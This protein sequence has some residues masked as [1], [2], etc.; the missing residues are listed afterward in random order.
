MNLFLLNFTISWCNYCCPLSISFNFNLL[1]YNNLRFLLYLRF[2]VNNLL[3]F[4]WLRRLWYSNIFLR[5][6]NLLL[7]KAALIFSYCSLPMDWLTFILIVIG[8]LN[9]VWMSNVLER[10]SDLLLALIDFLL[11][12]SHLRQAFVKVWILLSALL[13]I[14]ST[15]VLKHRQT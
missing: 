6:I 9:M 5:L 10:L 13:N 3:F 11:A 8:T 12:R 7:Y 15:K 4:H 1:L 14:F 2:W